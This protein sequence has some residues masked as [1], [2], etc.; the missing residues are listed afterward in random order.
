LVLFVANSLFV[1][2]TPSMSKN[3]TFIVYKDK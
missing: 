2:N 1:A 3:M